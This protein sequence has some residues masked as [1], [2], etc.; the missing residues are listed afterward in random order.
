MGPIDCPETSVRNYH[1]SLRNDPEERSSR[2]L[3]GGRLKS[4][5]TDTTSS[6]K[7]TSQKHYAYFYLSPVLFEYQEAQLVILE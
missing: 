1:H 2:L 3:R 7:S 6:N 4:H 5:V